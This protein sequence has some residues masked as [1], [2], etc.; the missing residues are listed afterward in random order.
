MHCTARKLSALDVC[1]VS[2]VT[3]L[4]AFCVL[5]RFQFGRTVISFCAVV[6]HWHLGSSALVHAGT[7]AH[8]NSR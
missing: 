2:A 8:W 7:L 3:V 4:D 1:V 5:V 6:Q